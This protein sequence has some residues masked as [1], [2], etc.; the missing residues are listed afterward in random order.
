MDGRRLG[1]GDPRQVDLDDPGPLPA[2]ANHVAGDAKGEGFEGGDR[3]AFGQAAGDA[4][5]HFIGRVL[6]A[7]VAMGGEKQDE[8]TA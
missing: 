1:G 2:F 7:G 3:G 4:I 5:E 8:A 6:G